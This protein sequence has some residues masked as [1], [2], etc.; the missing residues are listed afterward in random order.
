M[1]DGSFDVN[2]LRMLKVSIWKFR[3]LRTLES[4]FLTSL[5][6]LTNWLDGK[7]FDLDD[8]RISKSSIVIVQGPETF[9]FKILT[10][11]NHMSNRWVLKSLNRM[12][13]GS[14]TSKSKILTSKDI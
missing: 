8:P 12:F 3:L 11:C 9:K 10:S 6:H 1:D 7:S 4:K 2:V 14:N 5:G 13:W